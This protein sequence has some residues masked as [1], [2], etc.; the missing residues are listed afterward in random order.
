M[1][2]GSGHVWVDCKGP[3]E[4]L[5][6]HLDLSQSFPQ[7]GSVSLFVKR[8]SRAGISLSLPLL[9]APPKN[10][11]KKTPP[12]LVGSRASWCSEGRNYGERQGFPIPDLKS[13]WEV[14]W[15]ML[16]SQNFSQ[17]S[18]QISDLGTFAVHHVSKNQSLN[19]HTAPTRLSRSRSLISPDSPFP[20]DAGGCADCG[21]QM[22]GSSRWEGHCRMPD[23]FLLQEP[24]LLPPVTRV[25][26][27]RHCWAQ[28]R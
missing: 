11:N 3:D 2:R 25:T 16:R 13:F 6:H 20:F 1:G 28:A 21:R 5:T 12:L 7:S 19:P 24:R 23:G 15:K 9:L 4:P 14:G 18:C 27:G 8:G 22:V 26:R 17:P 10:K